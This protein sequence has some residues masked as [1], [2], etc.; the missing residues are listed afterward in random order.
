MT[1]YL[2]L[3]AMSAPHRTA[4]HTFTISKKGGGGE[5]ERERGRKFLNQ[6]QSSII[7]PQL[8]ITFETLMHKSR[9]SITEIP[10]SLLLLT[11][12]RFQPKSEEAASITFQEFEQGL[13]RVKWMDRLKVNSKHLM[14]L[15]T[16]ISKS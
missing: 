7:K 12:L 9:K 14:F 15:C 2:L 11:S 13:V 6:F 8:K 5:R 10:Q 1:C 4:K 16:S 3:N